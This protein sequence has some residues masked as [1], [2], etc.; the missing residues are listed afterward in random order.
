[1]VDGNVS[2]A[3][4]PWMVRYGADVLILGTSGLFGKAPIS[5]GRRPR[6]RARRRRAPR[7]LT[8]GGFPSRDGHR[9]RRYRTAT[10]PF[11]R[12]IGTTIHP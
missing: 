5:G 10:V 11:P 4:I 8:T 12:S 7:G 6:S 3:N 2:P 9:L 1:M